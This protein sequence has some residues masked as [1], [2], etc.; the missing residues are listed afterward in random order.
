[1]SLRR[2]SMLTLSLAILI[3]I[4]LAACS[5]EISTPASTAVPAPT[6]APSTPLTSPRPTPAP[7]TPAPTSMPSPT[8]TKAP[9][10]PT[11][12]TGKPATSA[13]TRA[14]STPASTPIPKPAAT[15]TPTPSPTPDPVATALVGVPGIVDP[16]NLGWPREVEGLNGLVSIPAKPQRIIGASIGH[17]E[18]ILAL[19]PVERLVAV[20]SF[21]K[22]ATYSNVYQLI[23]DKP[24]I[25]RD[26]ETII[27]QAPDVLVTS[28]FFPAEGIEALTRVGIPVV[29][30]E[31]QHDA[32]ARINN[33]LLVGYILGEEE[34]ALEFAAEVRERYESL[35]VVT[36]AAEPK[37][38]VLA[39][40]SFSDSLWTAGANSTEGGVIFA[41]GGINVAEVAGIESNKTISL[42]GVITM[43]PQV[44][45]IPQPV[46]FGA[47]EFR[48][49]LLANEALANV[50]A[51]KNEQVHVVESKHV[52]TLSYWN[53]RG[54]EDLAR[55][56][57]PDAFSE[58]PSPTFSLVE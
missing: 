18:V 45:I 52:T 54:A 14:P 46:E 50:P 40:T 27:A 20:G 34:R 49:S 24:E 12:S 42:E 57:W 58:E 10:T 44:I 37:P 33:I 30:T 51:I 8:P 2:S 3:A 43:N 28:P 48:D 21:S 41:A 23:Q 7:T 5:S 22:N 38:R 17:D 39:L 1:M 36:A 25:T 13:P 11:P 15:P 6:T 56:L 26:P 9:F 4:W 31:L 47:E 35:V 29:Q 19:V 55:I 16:T 53:I 32:K